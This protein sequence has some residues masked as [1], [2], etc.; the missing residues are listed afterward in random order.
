M[1]S[2]QYHV[3]VVGPVDA[4]PGAAEQLAAAMEQ[5]YGLSAADILSR[6]KRGRFRVKANI[7]ER[8]ANAYARDLGKIGAR[9]IIEHGDDASQ[10]QRVNLQGS[11]PPSGV[12]RAPT[13]AA[14]VPRA[15][16]PSL[17]S[18]AIR[19][20][21]AAAFN[22]SSAPASLGALEKGAGALSLAALDG[23]DHVEKPPGPEPN[24]APP[25]EPA[26]PPPAPGDVKPPVVRFVP[27]RPTPQQPAPTLGKP[28]DLFAPPAAENGG[29]GL[30]LEVDV[31][32]PVPTPA[33][34]SP[35]L[36]RSEPT[37]PRPSAPPALVARPATPRWRFAA[38]VV[39][40]IVLGFV[41]ANVVAGIR[42]RAADRKIDN[43]VAELYQ[44]TTT[45]EAFAQL[46]SALAPLRAK[47]Q[48]AHRNIALLSLMIWA[49]AGGALAYVWFRRIPWRS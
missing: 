24:F 8:T 15:Q 49:A 42:E 27:S 29:A 43:D 44:Q 7:D 41:P 45:E 12:P 38:G 17:G 48:A 35:P 25:P 40:A 1:A 20:G 30:E 6:L 28:V 21:L 18:G 47:K 34:T 23:S 3:F 22:D 19:S 4:S 26:K 14:G 31:A 39:L 46:D 2:G 33:P 36:R 16:T 10:S 37:L 9:A 5:R 13:P 32:K 11:T